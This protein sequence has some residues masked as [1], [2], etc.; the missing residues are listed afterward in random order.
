MSY[1]VAASLVATCLPA[2]AVAQ[3]ADSTNVHIQSIK[4]CQGEAD[5]TARL[6]CFDAAAAAIVGAT[7]KGE[8]KIV[9]REEVRKTRRKL[10][11]FSL[12]DFGIFGKKD[13]EGKDEEEIQELETTIASVSGSHG[14]GYTIR[15]AEGAVWRIDQV[16]RRLL[17]P[18]SGDKLL[19]KNAALSS[20]FIRINDQ[21]G[22][23]AVRVR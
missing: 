2:S 11:G 12:P 20:Y 16:P 8:L 19:I 6:A 4:A 18:K 13:K 14:T 23:K 17:E 22:V 9:D 1:L 7:E 10:F 3:E 15:T 5:P 21:G